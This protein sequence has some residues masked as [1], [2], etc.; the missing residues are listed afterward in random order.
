MMA[1]TFSSFFFDPYSPFLLGYMLTQDLL[2][3]AF[4]HPP[5]HLHGI[6]MY[7]LFP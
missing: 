3:D 7:L 2:N 1:S 4:R 5:N 6:E